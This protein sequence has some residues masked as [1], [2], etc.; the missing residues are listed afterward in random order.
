MVQNNIRVENIIRETKQVEIV[1]GRNCK[2]F[3]KEK[4]YN[5]DVVVVVTTSLEVE[6][7]IMVENATA[8]L[9]M[10]HQ[11]RKISC[12]IKVEDSTSK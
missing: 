5:K 6:N 9:K 8:W 1:N 7:V 10:Q 2:L 3:C 11:G 12:Y 4:G